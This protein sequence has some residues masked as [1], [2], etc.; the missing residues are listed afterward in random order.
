MGQGFLDEGAPRQYWQRWPVGSLPH[1]RNPISSI[2]HCY[3]S[4][5]MGVLLVFGFSSPG[6]N[7]TQRFALWSP[8]VG[9]SPQALQL[10]LRKTEERLRRLQRAGDRFACFHGTVEVAVVGDPGTARPN[11]FFKEYNAVCKTTHRVF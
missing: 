5:S 9:H 10:E 4:P 3:C 1:G 6:H 8:C 11:F 7:M 2:A